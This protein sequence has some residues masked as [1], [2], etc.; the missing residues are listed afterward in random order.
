[1]V[2]GLTAEAYAVY[3]CPVPDGNPVIVSINGGL[4]FFK[5]FTD[6]KNAAE[7]YI[8]PL[9]AAGVA[10]P[11]VWIEPISRLWTNGVQQ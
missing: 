11:Y 8:A 1:M 9:V 2:L 7:A 3:Q 5:S 4:L 10:P 6:A